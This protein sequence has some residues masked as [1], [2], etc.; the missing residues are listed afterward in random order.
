MVL[1]ETGKP[2]IQGLEGVAELREVSLKT[3][4]ELLKSKDEHWQLIGSHQVAG[5][6]AESK[7]KNQT[8][9]YVKKLIC[10]V[11]ARYSQEAVDRARTNGRYSR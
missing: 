4:N 11:M 2:A 6:V 8:V 10:Y 3:A 9:P 1:K 7:D 5:Y